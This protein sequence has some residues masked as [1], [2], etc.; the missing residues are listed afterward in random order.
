MT[1]P[2]VVKKPAP[3]KPKPAQVVK[4][5]PAPLVRTQE[6]D[7]QIGAAAVKAD[8]QT[9][10]QAAAARLAQIVNLHISGMSLAAIGAAIGA[11]ADE[12]DRMLAQD[13]QRYVRSQPALRV[14]VRNYVSEKYSKLLD[15]VWDEA[16]DKNHRA[17]LENQ[18][19]ALRIL[20]KMARLHGAEAPT[21]AE[22]KV[23]A[24]PEAVEKLVQVL[25]QAQGFGYDVDIFDGDVVDAELVHDA[26][27]QS[28]GALESASR[29]VE[30]EQPDDENWGDQP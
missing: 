2:V 7:E 26:V 11:S 8:A 3:V 14:Y 30:Q 28:A 18:D 20:D 23:E 6:Q 19:R 16:T 25:S 9:Q 12:V 5:K 1:D 24:A 22:V 4:P 13:T 21:Q 29:A 17:K 10:A 15:A 27:G